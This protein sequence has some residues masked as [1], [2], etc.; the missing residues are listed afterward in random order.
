MQSLR[1]G[2]YM[3]PTTIM[4]NNMLNTLDEE[5]YN[6]AISFIQFLSDSRKKKKSEQNKKILAE[7]QG[8]FSDDKGWENEAS[9][10]EEMSAF[11]RERMKK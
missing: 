5:D 6:T 3:A 8:I 10:I 9:M 1:K 2:V 7:I 4:I 11:R